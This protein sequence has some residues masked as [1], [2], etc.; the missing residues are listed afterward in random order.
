MNFLISYTDSISLFKETID[1]KNTFL[2]ADIIYRWSA[3]IKYIGTI[4]LCSEIHTHS[5]W[6]AQYYQLEK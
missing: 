3:L 6:P 5:L 4:L 2:V 1:D